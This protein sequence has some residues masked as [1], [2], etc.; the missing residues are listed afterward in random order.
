MRVKATVTFEYDVDK[1]DVGAGLAY[2]PK[3]D[4]EK[5]EQT[6]ARIDAKEIFKDPATAL[7]GEDITEVS[8][9]VIDEGVIKAHRVEPSPS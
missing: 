6:I 5:P 7:A 9:L 4:K 8:V 1:R 3:N 2:I